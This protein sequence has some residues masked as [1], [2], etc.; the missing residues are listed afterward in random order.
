M[1]LKTNW[2]LGLI[3]LALILVS[4]SLNTPEKPDNVVLIIIDTMRADRLGCYGYPFP[5]SPHIDALASEG[6]MFELAIT[7]TPV[8]LP[9]VSAI[10]TSTYPATNNVRYNGKFFLSDASITLAEILKEEGYKTAA[11]IGGFPLDS[12]FKTNQGF[13][14]YDD[15]FSGSSDK[16][17]RTWIGHG[18]SDFERTAAEVNEAAFAWLDTLGDDRFFLMIHYFDPHWPYQP[19]NSYAEKFKNSYNAE[20]AYT[21]EHVGGLLKKLE[22]LGLKDNTFIILTGDHGESLGAHGEA[23][24]GEFLFDTTLHVPLILQHENDIPRGHKVDTMVKTL[25]IMPTILDFLD[26]DNSPHSQGV[27][28]LPALDGDME[29]TPILLETMLP[30]YEVEDDSDVPT[31]IRG[32]RTPEWKMIYAT[33]EKDGKSQWAG[34]LYNVGKEPL[35]MFEVREQNKITFL[36]L[37]KEMLEMNKASS[38]QSVARDNYIDMDE[39]TRRK[40]ESLGYIVK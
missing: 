14:V 32:L 37:F 17:A 29:A 31:E 4:C 26:I 39:E 36:L 11:F 21:D 9:S 15:N 28:L 8:T 13:D 23:T 35:E 38:K 27:S 10:L 6:T 2:L 40:L 25:D 1:P 19:T 3:G 20:V 5:T 24:H 12:R 30:Y 33:F 18:V 22:D 34:E 16:R 7:C